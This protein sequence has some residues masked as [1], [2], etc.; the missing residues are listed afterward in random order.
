MLHHRV[1]IRYRGVMLLGLGAVLGAGAVISSQEVRGQKRPES[2]APAASTT[3]H[4]QDYLRQS[5]GAVAE[6]SKAGATDFGLGDSHAS[7]L[8]PYPSPCLE[9][10]RTPFDLW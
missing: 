5:P 10:M 2:Q 4:D 3:G 6:G 9:G 1:A 8:T 7:R